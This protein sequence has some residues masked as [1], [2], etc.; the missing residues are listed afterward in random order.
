[1]IIRISAAQI[2]QHDDWRP[3]LYLSG[4]AALRFRGD[5]WPCLGDM[6]KSFIDGWRVSR[7]PLVESYDPLVETAPVFRLRNILPYWIDAE[8]EHWSSPKMMGKSFCVQP[9]DIIIKKVGGASAALVSKSHSLH[10]VDA[11]LALVRGLPPDYA[12]WVCFSLNQPLYQEYLNET[13]AIS[14]LPRLSLK[15]L[16]Q[17]PICPMPE[18]FKELSQV[19]IGAY[20]RYAQAQIALSL[21]RHKVEQWVESQMGDF[22][23]DE[24]EN[25][26]Q[27]HWQF[28]HPVHI[29]NTLQISQVE[30]NYLCSQLIKKYQ[31]CRLTELSKINTKSKKNVAMGLGKVLLIGNVSE[32][33]TIK[34]PLPDKTETRW[35]LQKQRIRQYDVVMSTFADNTR[36]AYFADDPEDD[37]Y[38]TEQIAVLRF[39]AFPGAYA[40]LMESRLVKMQL[41]RL[42]SSGGFRF[43]SPHQLEQIVLPEIDPDIARSWHLKLVD[44]NRKIH[45]AET[46]LAELLQ[47]MKQ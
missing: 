21:L 24:W 26:A 13:E 5:S 33:M 43:L 1:M 3:S 46:Q 44:Y 34:Y 37:I 15:K 39:N 2:A 41:K 42:V 17:M 31:L 36:I 32:S 38:P 47:K 18:S 7:N 11:N 29:Q 23:W 14:T 22:D 35:R 4:G 28:F 20:N 27:C 19:F 6:A 16:K 12:V 10:P 40:L 9:L 25:P 45:H 30:Q 8:P